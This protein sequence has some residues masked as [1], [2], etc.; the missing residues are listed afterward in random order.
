MDQ[1]I[2]DYII[3][4]LHGGRNDLEILPEDDLLSSGLLESM[5]MMRLV[6]FIEQQFEIKV[7]PQEMT[8]E[9]FMNVESMVKFVQ[10][11]KSTAKK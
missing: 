7:P 2:I 3:N 5:S 10:Q 8:I 4:E 9:N 6:Q 1:T 11:N